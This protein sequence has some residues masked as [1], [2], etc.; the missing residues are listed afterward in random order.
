MH[1]RLLQKYLKISRLL[2]FRSDEI[3]KTKCADSWIPWERSVFMLHAQAK[4]SL[5]ENINTHAFRG[6]LK[7]ALSFPVLNLA[8]D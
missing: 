3:E 7:P 2:K 5:T 8:N 6:E 1:L 4:V